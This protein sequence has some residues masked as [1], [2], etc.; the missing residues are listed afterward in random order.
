MKN[1]N[2][3]PF[4]SI[5]LIDGLSGLEEPAMRG[6][7]SVLGRNIRIVGGST[8]DDLKFNMTYQY[9]DG[10]YNNAVINTIVAGL[11]MGTG[12]GHPY[13]P[14]DKGAVVTK[15]KDRTIYELNNRPAAEVL[16][17]LLDVDSLTPEILSENPFGLRSSD[18][19]GD[20]IIK[21][22]MRENPDGSISLYSEIYEG[23][24]L[25]IMET[26][27][28]TAIESFKKAIMMAIN[29]A[30]IEKEDVGA[31]VIFNCIL[32]HF[33]KEKLKINDVDIIKEVVG[34]VPVIGFNTYGEQGSTRGGA[35]G[36][37]NQTS[38]ILVISKKA[39]SQ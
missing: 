5:T 18:I 4:V 38:T 36:H 37:Y 22:A 3:N 27:R 1:L 26:D 34:D 24:Y 9:A 13:K 39:I 15:A 31:I 23:S 25:S 28:E 10:V 2:I 7:L 35:I 21:S 19:Y 6:I 29:D 17:E 12:M 8:G 33:L 20:Y 11:K 16:K 30:N 32:R 14:T